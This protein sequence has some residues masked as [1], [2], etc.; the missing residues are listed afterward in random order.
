MFRYNAR[1]ETYTKDEPT[2]TID[3]EEEE[4]AGGKWL[5]L[6]AVSCTLSV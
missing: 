1:A 6:V 5:L 3:E 4:K 2:K